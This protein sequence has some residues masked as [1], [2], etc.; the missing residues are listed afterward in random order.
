MRLRAALAAPHQECT[1][2]H[3]HSSRAHLLRRSTCQQLSRKSPAVRWTCRTTKEFARAFA[4]AAADEVIK[5]WALLSRSV[6]SVKW[7]S[8]LWLAA[9]LVLLQRH[10]H[11]SCSGLCR[12]PRSAEQ[13]E[14]VCEDA[15]QLG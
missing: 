1:A 4:C 3:R 5:R 15:A 8:V 10:A 9:C 2:S 11:D 7:A 14:R 6:T 12:R 13:P